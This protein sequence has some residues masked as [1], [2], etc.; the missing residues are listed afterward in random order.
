MF[1]NCAEA[2]RIPAHTR[3]TGVVEQIIEGGRPVPAWFLPGAIRLLAAM[4]LARAST[5]LQNR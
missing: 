5:R 4:A 3:L 1:I 2:K